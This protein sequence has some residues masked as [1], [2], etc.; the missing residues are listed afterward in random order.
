M[1]Q[2]WDLPW[3]RSAVILG[4][5]VCLAF[6]AK[7]LEDR[8]KVEDE[9]HPIGANTGVLATLLMA[10]V[11]SYRWGRGQGI[12]ST[13]MALGA[14]MDFQH[15]TE[16]HLAELWEHV[17]QVSV[18]MV[19]GVRGA[20]SEW[21]EPQLRGGWGMQGG[22]GLAT[23]RG[24]MF[25]FMFMFMLMLMLMCG[26]PDVVFLA[27]FAFWHC[28]LV[29]GRAQ[30]ARRDCREGR[31]YHPVRPRSTYKC[32]RPCH[33][34]HAARSSR[35]PLRGFRMGAE[36]NRPGGNL[37]LPAQ[38]SLTQIE[39]FVQARREHQFCGSTLVIHRSYLCVWQHG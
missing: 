29:L 26:I 7:M 39:R 4:Q 22:C 23:A 37:W 28:G 18:Q 34:G 10:G 5:G 19:V 2:L 38:V 11:A 15:E 35:T 30:H 12:C 25:M 3:K 21:E 1:T 8:W 20:W 31:G 14:S 6:G 32:R 33:F 36:S 17:A 16:A 13:A 9:I 27:A 24:F